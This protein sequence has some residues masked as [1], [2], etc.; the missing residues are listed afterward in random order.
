MQEGRLHL[1]EDLLVLRET[2]LEHSDLL[3]F[4]FIGPAPL[5]VE[6]LLAQG[7]QEFFVRHL[8]GLKVLEGSLELHL[9]LKVG[10]DVLSQHV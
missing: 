8:K 1:V 6:Q 10:H 4:L 2:F 3:L 9:L 7:V 5:E